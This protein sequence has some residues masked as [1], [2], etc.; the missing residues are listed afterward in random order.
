VIAQLGAAA[1]YLRAVGRAVR[2]HHAPLA[3]HAASLRRLARS[4]GDLFVR[5]A[6]LRAALLVST[7]VAARLG[8]TSLAAQQITFEIWSF[9]ALALDAVAIAGQALIGR[10]LGARDAVG[11]RRSGDR[12]LRWG[13]GAGVVLGAGVLALHELLPHVF[14][15]DPEVVE[16]AAFLLVLAALLQPLNGLVFTL[17]GI[18]IGAGDLRYLAQAM[19]VASAVFGVGAVAVLAADVGIGW[20]WAAIGAWMATRALTLGARY[21]TD[22]W[23]TLGT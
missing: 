10:Y 14:T 20:L 12:M 15:D 13:V 22:R 9:L 17:D 16:T 5:T 1:F 4:A 18:L 8:T 23:V 11:A 19:V 21:R 7:A 3:P 6:A 2:R